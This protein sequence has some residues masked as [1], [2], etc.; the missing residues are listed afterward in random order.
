MEINVKSVTSAMLAAVRAEADDAP[1]GERVGV[2]LGRG[3]DVG[4]GTDLLKQIQTRAHRPLV[5]MITGFGS[6][7]SAVSCMRDGAIDYIIKPFSSD[8]IEVTLKKA[9]EFTRLVKVTHFLSHDEGDESGFE[10]LGRSQPMDGLRQLIRKVART[11]ATVL[12]Q[13]ESGTGKELIARMLHRMSGRSGPLVDVNCA[14][15]TGPTVESASAD[16]DGDAA[17]SSIAVRTPA[18]NATAAAADVYTRADS[19]SMKLKI[20]RIVEV[21]QQR[22][23]RQITRADLG[24]RIVERLD[25]PPLRAVTGGI[26]RSELERCLHHWWNPQVAA[27]ERSMRW[28]KR[29]RDAPCSRATPTTRGSTTPTAAPWT[30]GSRCIS[31][32]RPATPAR[33][34]WSCRRTAALSCCNSWSHAVATS[35]RGWRGRASSASAPSSTTGWTWRRPRRSPT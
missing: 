8:T 33:T 21:G 27:M 17:T 25:Y 6:V 32:R 13:G 23:D 9:E 3:R 10:L 2:G 34:W 24:L 28:A 15:I 19:T 22:F 18:A 7:E 31:P 12:I 4:E 20:D 35:A 30:M 26:T 5:V 16:D 11:Q 14:A 1:V 29:S